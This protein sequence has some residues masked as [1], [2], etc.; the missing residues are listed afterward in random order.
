MHPQCQTGPALFRNLDS[1]GGRTSQQLLFS[2]LT[3]SQKTS[4]S[5]QTNEHPPQSDEAFSP[6]KTRGPSHIAG[7]RGAAKSSPMLPQHPRVALRQRGVSGHGAGVVLYAEGVSGLRISLV[8]AHS[9]HSL[10][11]N[12][13]VPVAR[14][15][16][17]PSDFPDAHT[18]WNALYRVV[19]HDVVRRATIR[20]PLPG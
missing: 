18:L 8:D 1:G 9:L 12:E 15:N 11:R 20:Y 13:A 4:P 2:R 5:C 19:I 6:Q 17:R 10:L 7:T 14:G 16:W 3:S